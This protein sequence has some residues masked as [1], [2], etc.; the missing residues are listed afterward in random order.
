MNMEGDKAF[1]LLLAESDLALTLSRVLWATG[2]GGSEWGETELGDRS[3]AVTSVPD[4]LTLP[5]AQTP[6]K[7]PLDR[8]PVIAS[9]FPAH[10]HR[11]IGQLCPEL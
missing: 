6:L 2:G 5:R 11:Y 9:P 7:T 8:L 3:L 1:F 4:Q 10:G